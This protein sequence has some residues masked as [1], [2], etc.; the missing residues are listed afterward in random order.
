MALQN[1]L[2]TIMEMT[3]V[4]DGGERIDLHIHNHD[5]PEFQEHEDARYYHI[6]HMDGRCHLRSPSLNERA[7]P[8]LAETH[9][10]L[11]VRDIT[12][13]DGREG[14]VI[15]TLS[16][17][18]E[19]G[20]VVAKHSLHFA[21]AVSREGLDRILAMQR[22]CAVGLGAFL[23][24]TAVGVALLLTKRSFKKVDEFSSHLHAID[25]DTLGACLAAQ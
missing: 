12:L 9:Q 11:V 4:H 15:T 5:H 7:L 18:E 23:V 10:E 19:H 16:E 6:S 21:L 13:P 24:A 14:R 20:N 8:I 17:L 1:D 25:F 3:S 22:W 2:E